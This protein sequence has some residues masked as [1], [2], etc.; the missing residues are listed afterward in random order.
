MYMPKV[1]PT[2]E[3]LV[4]LMMFFFFLEQ[5]YVK[6]GSRR[7]RQN[8]SMPIATEL[9]FRPRRVVASR[10]ARTAR[11]PTDGGGALPGRVLSAPRD[12][13]SVGDVPRMPILADFFSPRD[14]RP[15]ATAA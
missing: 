5:Q 3:Q 11:G 13:Q 12:L 10:A 14:A 1:H 8:G 9:Y 6:F 7:T 15:P 2:A 4:N